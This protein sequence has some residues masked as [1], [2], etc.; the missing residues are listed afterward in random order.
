ME[1]TRSYQTVRLSAGSHTAPSDGVCVLE[2]A[3]MLNEE[4]FSDRPRS[5]CPALREFL[6]GYNDGLPDQ[7]RQELFAL[8]SEIVE[9]HGPP[10]MTAWRARLCVDWATSVA[11]IERMPTRFDNSTLVD[12]A[13][14][15][16]YAA[17]VARANPWC[18]KQTLAFFSW[19]ARK[20]APQHFSP[21]PLPP[22]QP[23][24]QYQREATRASAATPALA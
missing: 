14:A 7:L 21:M 4:P 2:L 13:R 5:V 16:A 6:Q 17:K 9:T 1:P 11:K 24:R 22:A 10:R 20:S 3:S 8:A 15:G 18:H 12:C 19:L 23:Q